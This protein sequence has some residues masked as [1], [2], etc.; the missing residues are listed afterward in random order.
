MNWLETYQSCDKTISVQKQ[1]FSSVFVLLR[2]EGAR[3]LCGFRLG[4]WL[5]VHC[6]YACTQTQISMRA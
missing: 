6:V 3:R 1:Y 2:E 5:H 4:P